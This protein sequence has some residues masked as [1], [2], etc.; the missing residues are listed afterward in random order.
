MRILYINYSSPGTGAW[1]H[2]QQFI[3]AMRTLNPNMTVYPILPGRENDSSIANAG[4]RNHPSTRF[5]GMRLLAA[6]FAR[7]IIEEAR[8]LNNV[9]PDVV[10][11]RAG[12]YLSSVLISRYK[13]IPILLEINGSLVLENRLLEN[14]YRLKFEPFWRWLEKRVLIMGSHLMVVSEPLRQ[15]YINWGFTPEKITTVP[16]GVNTQ[17]FHPDIDGLK[18]RK[19]F[20]L[21]GKIVIG[22]SGAFSAWHGLDFLLQTIQPLSKERDDIALLLIGRAKRDFTLPQ[23]VEDRVIMTGFVPY[24]HMPE[25]LAAVDIFIAP[26]PQIDPFYFSPLKIFEAM[27]MGKAVLASS[28]GQIRELIIDGMEGLLYPPGD[29]AIFLKKLRLLIS[30]SEVRENLGKRARR[31]IEQQFTWRHN[32]QSVMEL[33]RNLRRKRS[34]TNARR[35]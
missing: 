1:V 16:N 12:R 30:N 11:L 20:S 5:R 34:M 21:E 33:C 8:V 4:S 9:K 23:L 32:A 26:Y 24:E 25:H 31:K 10:I 14:Q 13:K 7:K 27:A 29:K 28:Q 22:F 3:S 35:L 6:L 18:V 17:I 19:N 15:H 2:S